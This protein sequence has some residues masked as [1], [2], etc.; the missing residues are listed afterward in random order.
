MSPGLQD[1][2]Q[3]IDALELAIDRL[4][5]QIGSW[6]KQ[7]SGVP[8][9]C[10]SAGIRGSRTEVLALVATMGDAQAFFRLGPGEFAS[11][12]GFGA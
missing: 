7:E 11:F 2:L 3:R 4:E 9:D 6:Q 8:G 5:R 10:G 12:L 1:Q